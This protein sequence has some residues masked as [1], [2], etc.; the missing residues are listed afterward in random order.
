M[1]IRRSV[2]QPSLMLFKLL[3]FCLRYYRNRT[4][5]DEWWQL[6]LVFPS[7]EASQVS[8]AVDLTALAHKAIS[9]LP[10]EAKQ[11]LTSQ[12]SFSCSRLAAS[13]HLRHAFSRMAATTP[14]SPHPCAPTTLSTWVATLATPPRWPVGTWMGLQGIPLPPVSAAR[15]KDSG[16]QTVAWRRRLGSGKK[17]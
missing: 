4:W 3:C 7:A 9:F 2:V 10:K 1:E 13:A 8:N 6:E 14:S 17:S 15:Q 16:R 5:T 11:A 12:A